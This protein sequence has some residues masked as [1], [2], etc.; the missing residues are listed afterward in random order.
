MIYY[1]VPLAPLLP[2][3]VDVEF[4]LVALFNY[5]CVQGHVE[6][7]EDVTERQMGLIRS[8]E[9]SLVTDLM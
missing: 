4:I 8:T 3:K 1:T 2:A 5:T 6:V 9:S 7:T